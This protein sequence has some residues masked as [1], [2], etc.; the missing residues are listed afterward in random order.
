MVLIMTTITIEYI[1]KSP[2]W[3]DN[4][5]G[6]GIAFEKGEIYKLPYHIAVKLLRHSDCFQEAIG[7][8]TSSG[9]YNDS[10]IK[11]RLLSIEEVN[12]SQTTTINTLQG[13]LSANLDA[14]NALTERVAVLE[15]AHKPTGSL[16][17]AYR[18]NLPD[19]INIRA[20]ED[21]SEYLNN[22]LCLSNFYQGN[23]YI[24]IPAP[25]L[26]INPFEYGDMNDYGEQTAHI[27]VSLAFAD[28]SVLSKNIT[29]IKSSNYFVEQGL[30]LSD[31]TSYID[32]G[33]TL[34]NSYRFEVTGYSITGASVL[35][36]AFESNTNRTTLRI[37]VNSNKIQSMWSGNVEILHTV[38]GIQTTEPFYY[39]QD[40]R[41][42]TLRQGAIEYTTDNTN[43]A[44]V[45]SAIPLCLLNEKDG[46]TYG[47]GALSE[48][49]IFDANDN[50]LRHFQAWCYRGEYVFLD[51]AN[52][53]Q[54]YRPQSGELLL[55]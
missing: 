23:E 26:S 49:K 31:K 43:T 4:A 2:V 3:I 19:T 36:G 53:N 47:N 1:G 45:N 22:L 39:R 20:D 40:K 37:L 50:L 51:I 25:V 6:S 38:S 9:E 27:T 24:H 16:S 28:N 34:D 14:D 18:L 32:T 29:V 35:L 7:G 10:A 8:T 55:P 17:S 13:D 12:Q 44:S 54:I 21:I 41:Q 52:N 46:S 42:V 11:R 30:C 15:N 48:A 5:Y 33:L